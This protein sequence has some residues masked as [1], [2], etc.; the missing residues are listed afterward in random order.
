M[1]GFFTL[2]VRRRSGIRKNTDTEDYTVKTIVICDDNPSI[3][4]ELKTQIEQY[5]TE[6]ILIKTFTFPK[7]AEKYILSNAKINILLLDIVLEDEDG[8]LLAKK[9][10]RERPDVRII[11]IT[12]YLEQTR[13]IFQAGPVYFLV[14]PIKAKHLKLVLENVF[15]EIEEEE[16]N[17][18]TLQLKTGIR[19][20]N[21]KSIFYIESQI[22]TLSIHMQ[23]DN[24]TIYMKMDDF[25]QLLPDTFLRVHKSF[26]VNMD[27]ISH[28]SSGG[29]VLENEAKIPISRSRYKE[30]KNRFLGYCG[31]ELMGRGKTEK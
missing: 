31:N 7:K 16:K 25:I 10:R 26:L 4:K 1:K 18:I 20:I 8:I 13:R 11:F 21:L 19:K 6:P 5:L 24:E 29:I 12:G 23:K 17:Y 15:S 28:F 9:I 22:R 27:K 14:K 3:L 30:A 2:K